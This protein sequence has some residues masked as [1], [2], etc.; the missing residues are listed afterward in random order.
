[1]RIFSWAYEMSEWT[2][3]YANPKI[4]ACEFFRSPNSWMNFANEKCEFA[5]NIRRIHGNLRI[6]SSVQY[7]LGFFLKHVLVKSCVLLCTNK[8]F[9]MRVAKFQCRY[10]PVSVKRNLFIEF[11]WI[12]SDDCFSL[13]H[14]KCCNLIGWWSVKISWSWH[15]EVPRRFFLALDKQKSK[16]RNVNNGLPIVAR[17]S[18]STHIHHCK[19]S[20]SISLHD[21]W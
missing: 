6:D 10:L 12:T 3:S 5:E 17:N 9:E 16:R 8:Q 19:L 1:M 15:F 18:E 2:N 14:S 21:F 4:F 20:V 11:Y 13:P 7:V